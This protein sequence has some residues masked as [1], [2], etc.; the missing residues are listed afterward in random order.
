MFYVLG[1]DART[2]VPSKLS[3]WAT[4]AQDARD[5]FPSQPKPGD[6]WA[7][8]GE[9]TLHGWRIS[10]IFVGVN[11]RFMGEGPPLVFETMIFRTDE[12]YEDADTKA[13]AGQEELNL[14]QARYSTW[15]EAL[16]GHAIAVD[17]V[18]LYTEHRA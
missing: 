17:L 16:S 15:D 5:S 10:T 12:T 1:P 13:P 11:R 14:W 9:T 18:K 7:Q 3:Q 4:G 2:A 6:G 8:V